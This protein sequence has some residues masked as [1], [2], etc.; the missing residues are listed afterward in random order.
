MSG[1][2][3][4]FALLPGLGCAPRAT[5]LLNLTSSRLEVMASSSETPPSP[6]FSASTDTTATATAP[7]PAT[8]W[9]G[10]L[11]LREPQHAPEVLTV[12]AALDAWLNSL[13]PPPGA[14]PSLGNWPREE[15]PWRQNVQWLDMGAAM[16]CVQGLP[17]GREVGAHSTCLT[18]GR[19]LGAPK[20]RDARVD[21]AWARADPRVLRGQAL[22]YVVEIDMADA[23]PEQRERA[24]GELEE[25]FEPGFAKLRRFAREFW[26]DP[27]PEHPRDTPYCWAW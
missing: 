10:R 15:P 24:R 23:A 5:H 22:E 11:Q 1:E 16:I 19:K 12:D 4:W 14:W 7:L 20:G 3:R 18:Y 9:L 27:A 26:R 17:M 13:K 2:L 6:S 25:L 21:E 8:M